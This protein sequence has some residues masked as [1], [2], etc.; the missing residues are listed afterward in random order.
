VKKLQRKTITEIPGDGQHRRNVTYPFMPRGQ[1]CRIDI[2]SDEVVNIVGM[3]VLFL[4]G[5]STLPE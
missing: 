4:H 1:Y 2:T 3:S 5:W